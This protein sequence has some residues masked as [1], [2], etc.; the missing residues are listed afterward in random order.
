[1]EMNV[2]DSVSF[3]QNTTRNCTAESSI[4]AA[5]Q[6]GQ[7]RAPYNYKIIEH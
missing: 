2:H 3:F 1:M 6:V 5:V 4:K 7:E